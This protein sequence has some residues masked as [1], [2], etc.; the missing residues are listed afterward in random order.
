[1][2]TYVITVRW[3]RELLLWTEEEI[4]LLRSGKGIDELCELLPHRTRKTIQN[5]KAKVAPVQKAWTTTERRIL[6][7]Y[8]EE[9]GEG[10]L[11]R[12]PGRTWDSIRSQVY[13]L[14]KRG[15]NI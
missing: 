15:W 8:Y 4:F 7:D 13:Y 3:R 1:M 9:E 2:E 5:K 11:P 12:L 10:I 6:E 14:R